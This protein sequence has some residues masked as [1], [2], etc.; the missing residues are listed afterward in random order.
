MET[1]LAKLPRQSVEL[2]KDSVTY[3]REATRYRQR[4]EECR[5][6]AAQMRDQQARGSVLRT[7]ETYE[8]LARACA[9]RRSRD[10]NGLSP[11]RPCRPKLVR[12]AVA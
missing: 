2:P 8:C 11:R 6:V 10:C 5:A 4:A 3:R 12:L 9:K 1:K 7:A